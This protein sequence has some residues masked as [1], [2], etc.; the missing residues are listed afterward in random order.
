MGAIRSVYLFS[1]DDE[2]LVLA[3]FSGRLDRAIAEAVALSGRDLTSALAGENPD[4]DLEEDPEL[5]V[6]HESSD[7][8]PTAEEIAG[9]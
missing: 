6:D 3:R 8:L 7:A 1:L 4:L 5:V 2:T 9:G